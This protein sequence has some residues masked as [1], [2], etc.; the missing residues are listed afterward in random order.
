MT[1][2]DEDE[3]SAKGKVGAVRVDAGMH[4]GT[5]SRRTEKCRQR[6]T[7]GHGGHRTARHCRGMRAARGRAI[8]AAAGTGAQARG[9]PRGAAG[10]QRRRG[11]RLPV[12]TQAKNDATAP[13]LATATAG[14]AHRTR[15]PTR[16]VVLRMTPPA[17]T[18]RAAERPTQAQARDRGECPPP[19]PARA[20]APAPCPVSLC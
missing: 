3:K 8:A 10:R 7:R 4:A 11:A 12:S 16:R 2:G 20:P 14:V 6:R 1:L 13:Q 18:K 15:T 9:A 5:P 19:E 17:P